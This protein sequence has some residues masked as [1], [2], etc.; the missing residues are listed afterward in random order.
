MSSDTSEG[1]ESFSY[2]MYK[3]LRDQ[4]QV[5]SGLLARF[6]VSLNITFQGQTERASGEL[7]S[8]NYF[9]VLGVRAALGRTDD[10]R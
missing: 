4:N 1:A 9:D 6:A 3:D 10:T 2:P 8:G 7:V 5:F